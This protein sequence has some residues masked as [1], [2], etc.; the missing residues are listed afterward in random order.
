MKFEQL[1]A[2]PIRDVKRRDPI[3]VVETTTAL[4]VVQTMTVNGTGSVLVTGANGQLAGIF[5][6]N[7]LAKRI[8]LSTSEWQSHPISRYMTAKIRTAR[9]DS[10]IATALLTMTAGGFRHLPII[11][12]ENTPFA[13]VS[14]RD[15]IAH[16]AD[17]FP[18]EFLNLPSDPSH[19]AHKPW[20]G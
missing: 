5:T 13:I 15:V 16:I 1:A 4:E 20:G 11:D 2:A 6:E 8:D 19:E 18:K 7:D 3:A 14:I 12:G 9:C 10:S 17:C